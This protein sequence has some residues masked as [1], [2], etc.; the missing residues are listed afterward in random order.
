VSNQKDGSSPAFMSAARSVFSIRIAIGIGPTPPGTGVIAP[1][2]SIA[3]AKATSP[4]SFVFGRPAASWLSPVTRLMPTST[5][6]APSLIRAANHPGT[7]DGGNDNIG[8]QLHKDSVDRRIG[9]EL[10]DEGKQLCFT[11][12][13]GKVVLDRVKPAGLRGLAFGFDIDLTCRIFTDEGR[14]LGPA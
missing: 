4:T 1:A 3:S 2:G 6:I 8:S 10:F 13:R 12:R 9:I 14:P 7:A 5:M 11:G